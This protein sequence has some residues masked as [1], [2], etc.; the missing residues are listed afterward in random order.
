MPTATNGL[1]KNPR[2]KPIILI[3]KSILGLL[4]GDNFTKK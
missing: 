2:T 4:N 1:R 3:V